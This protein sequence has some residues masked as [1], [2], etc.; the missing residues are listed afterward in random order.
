MRI[1]VTGASGFVGRATVARLAAAGHTVLPMKLRENPAAP[2]CDAV[3][4]L[5]GEPIAQRWT[6]E[7]KRRIRESR[8]EGTRRLVE[9]FRGAPPR[10]LVAASAIGYYGSRG[11][12]ILTEDSAPGAGFLAELCVEWERAAA[13]ARFL[14]V[15]VIQLRIGMALG[16]GGG[17]L[18]RML[19][20]FRLAVGAR[21]GSGRQWMSWIHVEDLAALIEFALNS[22][23]G[24]VNAVAPQPVTNAEFTRALASAVRRP[25]FAVAPAFLLKLLLGEMSDVLLSSQRVAPRAAESAGFTFRYPELRAAL[26]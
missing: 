6:A 13:E 24:P 26:G 7:A 4:H 2:P 10:T 16:R 23:D 11:D 8:V 15:R 14:G 19:P 3:V 21:L 18:P 25:A 5:A 17:A 20:A 12:E 1:A 9:S 22:L